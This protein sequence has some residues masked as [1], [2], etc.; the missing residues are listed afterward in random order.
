MAAGL[1]K[2]HI[3]FTKSGALGSTPCTQGARTA[4]PKDSEFERSH[5]R[6]LP[7]GELPVRAALA[8]TS[9]LV[10]LLAEAD[11]ANRTNP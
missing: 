7:L 9:G 11:R 6:T 10:R 4:T 1:A 3:C 2:A 5:D 8:E